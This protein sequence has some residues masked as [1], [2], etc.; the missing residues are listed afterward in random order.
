ML[1]LSSNQIIKDYFLIIGLYLVYIFLEKIAYVS[2][3]NY[4]EKHKLLGNNQYGLRKNHSISLA[5]LH[6]HDKITSAVD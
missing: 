4:L 6:L 3:I 5:L 2:L 1:F